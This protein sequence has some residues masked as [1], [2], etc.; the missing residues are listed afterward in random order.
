MSAF[1]HMAPQSDGASVTDINKSLDRTTFGPPELTSY[2]IG[3]SS[4]KPWY[5]VRRLL[6]GF[7]VDVHVRSA[8]HTAIGA[9]STTLVATTI[10]L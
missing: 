9:L 4:F 3:V 6:S 1:V 7:W 2:L 8:G 10:F 5:M